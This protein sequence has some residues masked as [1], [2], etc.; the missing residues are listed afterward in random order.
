M[1]FTHSNKRR[2]NYLQ[3]G[4]LLTTSTPSLYLPPPPLPPPPPPPPPGSEGLLG[5]AEKAFFPKDR[6]LVV[7]A[8]M[9]A[10]PTT[11]QGTGEILHGLKEIQTQKRFSFKRTLIYYDTLHGQH[12][13]NFQGN[14][15]LQG[16]FY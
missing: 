15:F 16:I 8:A 13:A 4:T 2:D 9:R 14:P 11:E 12:D 7:T 10:V 3:V 5:T 6:E 1:Q